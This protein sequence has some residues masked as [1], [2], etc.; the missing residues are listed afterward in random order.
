MDPRPTPRLN[1]A[2]LTVRTVKVILLAAAIM[3]LAFATNKAED[4]AEFRATIT[5]H[6]LL[7]ASAAPVAATAAVSLEAGLAILALVALAYRRPALACT[8]LGAWFAVL[9]LYCLGLVLDPPAKPVGC[10]CGFSSTPVAS[11]LP[12]FVGNGGAAIGLACAGA[13]LGMQTRPASA[14]AAPQPVATP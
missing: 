12:L 3:L 7:P 5:A 2:A 6:G 11:W 9:A 4:L 8:I 14:S 13:W 1:L 10:G